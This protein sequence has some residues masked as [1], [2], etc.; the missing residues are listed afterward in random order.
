MGQ[1]AADPAAA[2]AA[3]VAPEDVNHTMKAEDQFWKMSRKL[4]GDEFS[5]GEA[6]RMRLVSEVLPT[7]QLQEQ[8]VAVARRLA[9]AP[10]TLHEHAR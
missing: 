8:A 10:P 6:L 7:S 2:I 9:K 1:R 4:T 3:V 5:V